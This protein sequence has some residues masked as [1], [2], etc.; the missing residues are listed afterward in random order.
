MLPAN[1]KNIPV[2]ETLLY[3]LK[4]KWGFAW[5]NAGEVTF[6]TKET[7][8]LGKPIFEFSATGRTYSHYNSFFKVN[9]YFESRVD[10]SSFEPIYF[11]RN[12]SEGKYKL[13]EF[14]MYNMDSL[15]VKH[16]N[17]TQTKP[18]IK[19]FNIQTH[20]RDLLSLIY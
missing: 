4:Y 11:K 9:D 20:T 10:K 7:I 1:P 3:R 19:H 15:R 12:I 16:H 17:L 18:K 6:K 2:K 13:N 5:L 8:S 14:D